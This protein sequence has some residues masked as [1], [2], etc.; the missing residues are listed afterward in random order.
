MGNIRPKRYRRSYQSTSK[1]LFSAATA[2]FQRLVSDPFL[3][4][5]LIFYVCVSHGARHRYIDRLLSRFFFSDY[6]IKN[7]LIFQKCAACGEKTMCD[8]EHK[9][10]TYILNFHKKSGKKDKDKDGNGE[11][12][13][14]KSKDKDKEKKKVRTMGEL[15]FVYQ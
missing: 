10:T 11:K 7:G 3:I 15:F 4:V 13:E 6:K 14:K 9:L 12:K 5:L 8:M 1:I 2:T